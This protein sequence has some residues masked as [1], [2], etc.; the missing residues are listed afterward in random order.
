M[1]KKLDEKSQ[2]G[3]KTYVYRWRRLYRVS[4]ADMTEF[5]Q[6]VGMKSRLILFEFALIRVTDA[7]K[8]LLLHLQEY[9]NNEQ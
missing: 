1:K 7:V 8:S 9:G 5:R 6:I 2:S 3:E 4:A